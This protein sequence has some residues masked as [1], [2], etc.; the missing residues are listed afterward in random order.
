VGQGRRRSKAILIV[1]RRASRRRS[2]D[3]EEKEWDDDYN[4]VSVPIRASARM[5]R[6]VMISTGHGARKSEEHNKKKKQF[7]FNQT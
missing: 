1:P 3:K 2:S 5:L 7:D 6:I 4:R